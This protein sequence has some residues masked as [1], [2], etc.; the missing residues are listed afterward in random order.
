MAR[1]NL[2]QGRARRV[3]AGV[4]LA[5]VLMTGDRTTAARAGTMAEAPLAVGNQLYETGLS[6]IQI[7]VPTNRVGSPAC[8]PRLPWR[9]QRLRAAQ[10]P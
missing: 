7:R 3:L 10:P 2:T 6:G 9:R 1:W 4:A 8:H 5:A